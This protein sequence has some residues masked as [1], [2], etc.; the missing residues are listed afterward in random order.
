MPYT[1]ATILETQRIG[2]VVSPGKR[3]AV[4]DS[5]L[6]GTFYPKVDKHKIKY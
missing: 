4:E 3:V 5:I 2:T 6:D 1:Q